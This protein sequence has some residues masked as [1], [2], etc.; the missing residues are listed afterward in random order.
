VMA[1]ADEHKK[2]ALTAEKTWTN[3]MAIPEGYAE[4]PKILKKD[5]AI[6]KASTSSSCATED[7]FLLCRRY[8]GSPIIL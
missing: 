7:A 8:L 6:L 5:S 1:N 4:K 3:R 2:L